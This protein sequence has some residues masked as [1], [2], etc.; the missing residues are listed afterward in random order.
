MKSRFW[1]GAVVFDPPRQ[2]AEMQ[3]RDLAPAA[4]LDWKRD[5]S[6]ATAHGA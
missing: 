6:P 1:L 5:R 3:A 4:F 2:G